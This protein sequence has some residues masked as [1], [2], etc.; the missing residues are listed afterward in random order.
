MTDERRP[1]GIGTAIGAGPRPIGLFLF[2]HD[3]DYARAAAAA[4]IDGF[5]VDLESAGKRERQAGADT[6]INRN[7][8]AD[9]RRCREA[10]GTSRI[11]CRVNNLPGRLESE[12]GEVVSAGADEVFVPMVLS[13]DEV[14]RA[15]EAIAGR[16][17]LDLMIETEWAVLHAAELAA[18]PVRRI[19]VGLHDLAIQRGSRSLWEGLR[20]GTVERVR[21]AV[22]AIDFGFG[23]MTLPD[24][25]APIPSRLLSAELE[26]LCCDFTFLRRSFLRDVP[27]DSLPAAV[28]AMRAAWGEISARTEEARTRNHGE[29]RAVLDG[30]FGGS[31]PGEP[32]RA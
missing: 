1:R 31:S 11:L 29:L 9:V 18:L 7:V 12:I 21:E 10:V 6:E 3:E 13:L 25:G 2:F 16:A 14:R 27:I 22:G 5:V 17:D 28:A 26:R 30:I 4:G 15:E 24:R 23:G 20:D 8:P 32:L 19:F